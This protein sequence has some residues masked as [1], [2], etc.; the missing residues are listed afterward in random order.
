[1]CCVYKHKYLQIGKMKYF[2][3]NQVYVQKCQMEV[4]NI[5]GKKGREISF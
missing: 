4:Q 5:R 2:H 3:K 1:M